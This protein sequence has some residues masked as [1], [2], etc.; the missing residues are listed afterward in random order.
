MTYLP[1]LLSLATAVPPFVLKQ[2]EV[3]AQARDLFAHR[4]RDID[5]LMPVFTNAGIETRRSC[6]PLEWYR[7]AADWKDRNAIYVE[8]A[9]EVLADATL[10]CLNQADMAVEEVDA[11]ITV[12]TTGIATPSL[13]ARLMNKL[14]LRRDIIRLPVFGLGCAGGVLGLSRA[15]SFAAAMPGK[16][17]LLLVVELC[18]LT[19]RPGDLSKS[20]VIAAALFG[21]GA[22]A[23]LVST[24]APAA[25]PHSQPLLAA[26][27]EYTWP[28]S[29]DVMGWHIEDDGFGVLF[30]RDIPA[31]IA[32]RF[33]PALDGFL[34]SNALSRADLSEYVCH[35]GGTKVLEAL[36]S[37]LTL[38][39]GAMRDARDV[40]RE[41]GN[42]S[43]ATVLFVL[44][45]ALRRSAGERLLMSSL[46]PGFTVAFQVLEQP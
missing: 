26:A 4:A 46:G 38:P 34:A 20:N 28:D 19:F 18:A 41:Y 12:S 5:R 13:D 39:Q 9:V 43:A 10:K 36:E 25:S 8:S 2:T 16:N 27:G 23:A 40:L 15:A 42:M 7:E 22:A 14:G 6:V 1:K 30:S 44:E 33:G 45:R 11:I 3:A 31:I 35:P 29:L 37:T 32:E 17:V 24:R 21:D